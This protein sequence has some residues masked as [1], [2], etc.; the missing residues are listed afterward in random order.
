MSTIFANIKYLLAPVLILVTFAGVLAGGI[1]AW[2]GV[3]LLFVGIIIDTVLKKQASSVMHGDSGETLASPAFQNLV[4]YFMLPVFVMLQLALAWR[5]YG[6]S[7]I[8]I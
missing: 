6:L 7:L 3:G 5:V 8:H 1:F 4:M 2:L